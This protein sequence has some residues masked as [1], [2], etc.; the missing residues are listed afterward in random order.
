[1]IVALWFSC[2]MFCDVRCHCSDETDDENCEIHSWT[3]ENRR[4]QT[5]TYVTTSSWRNSC[6][7]DAKVVSSCSSD[8]ADCRLVVVPQRVIASVDC[9]R[10][11]EKSKAPSD[12]YV[13]S[14]DLFWR[15][16]K[17]QQT[18][19]KE[20]TETTKEG[21]GWIES[22]PVV[23][24]VER[25]DPFCCRGSYG[26]GRLPHQWHLNQTVLLTI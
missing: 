13:V 15:D 9:C 10:I 17:H 6:V 21:D 1:M 8:A 2:L 4:S 20:A 18:P 23:H 16:E 14:K 7:M 24:R 19:R 12:T 22:I 26:A 3:P 11:P 25:V 5:I